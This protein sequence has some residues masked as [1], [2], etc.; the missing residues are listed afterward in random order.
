MLL[1]LDTFV[2][3]SIVFLLARV[4]SL[5]WVFLTRVELE[6]ICLHCWTWFPWIL[7]SSYWLFCQGVHPE[8]WGIHSYTGFLPFPQSFRLEFLEVVSYSVLNFKQTFWLKNPRNKVQKWF[9]WYRSDGSGA[10]PVLNRPHVLLPISPKSVKFSWA[11]CTGSTP[12]ICRP[13]FPPS[14][15]VLWWACMPLIPMSGWKAHK[16][17]GPG[18]F[19]GK[20]QSQKE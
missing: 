3:G 7:N 11:V 14:L 16:M 12:Q 15:S 19:K 20:K 9:S 4:I 1:K 13:P 8:S 17:Y 6:C 10:S 18:N 5:N 2:F